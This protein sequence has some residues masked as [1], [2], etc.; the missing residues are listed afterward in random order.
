MHSRGRGDRGVFQQAWVL[1]VHKSGPF[2]KAGH[3]HGQ[4]TS[5]LQTPVEPG[6][7]LSPPLRRGTAKGDAAS[8]VSTEIMIK[9]TVMPMNVSGS[10][11]RQSGGSTVGAPC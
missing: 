1:A 9:S 6:L 10:N 4:M 11:P 5:R 7:A 3:I 2:T 8:R